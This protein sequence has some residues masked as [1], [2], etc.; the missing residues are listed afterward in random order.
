MNH[1]LL[2]SLFLLTMTH[3]LSSPTCQNI[4]SCLETDVLSEDQQYERLFELANE[5]SLESSWC[6]VVAQR[7]FTESNL[8][9]RDSML[10]RLHK[11]EE[12][13]TKMMIR[14]INETLKL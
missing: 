2:Y 4:F 10:V 9:S 3:T 5:T 14:Q 6:G 7:F 11:I 13:L 1:F 8:S 12:E